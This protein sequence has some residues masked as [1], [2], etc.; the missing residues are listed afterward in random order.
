[1]TALRPRDIALRRLANQRLIGDLFAGPVE[2]V[3]RLGAVQSQDY[4]GAKW[5]VAM[6]T[7][8]ATD[9]EVDRALD[10]GAILRTHVLRPTW[11]FVAAEDIRWMLAL[12][13]PRVRARMAP[14]NRHLELDDKVFARSAAAITKALIGGTQLTRTELGDILRRARIDSGVGQRLAHLMMRAELDGLVCSGARKGKQTTYALLEERVPPAPALQPD[15]ALAELV[16]RYFATRAPATVQDF[17]WWSGLSVG[18]ARRGV[19]ALQ[20]GLEQETIGRRTYWYAGDA[21]SATTRTI[22]AHLLPNYDE[23]F[24]GFK[25]R[26]AIGGR[27]RN[28]K[29]SGW[30]N[31]AFFGHLVFVNGDLVGGWKRVQERKTSVIVFTMVAKL[32]AAERVL[33]DRAV[34]KF[35]TFLGQSV[36]TRWK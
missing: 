17:A 36:E 13:A 23:Y 34:A 32:T 10:D 33:V 21:T 7:A 16:R 24:I 22:A 8:A 1:M 31:A 26:S 29:L 30:Q 12:T 6:R 19:A 27:V 4:A 25:D 28:V 3:R 2:V 5:G 20:P 11:H 18:D 15:E 14:Y 9:A 35:E